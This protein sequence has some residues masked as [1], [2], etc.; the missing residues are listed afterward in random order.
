MTDTSIRPPTL[1]SLQGRLMWPGDPGY[2][3]ARRVFNAIFDRRPA[4]VV[5]C[6]DSEDVVQGLAYARATGAEV[7]VYGGGHAVTGAAVADGAVCLDL[8]GMKGIDIDPVAQVARVDAGC[9]WGEFDAAAQEHGLAVTGGRV[10][11]TGV[12]GL[13]LGSGSGWLER[14]LGYTC[15]SLLAAEVVTADG[16][17]VTASAEV[18][19]ELFWGIRGG[20]GNFGVVTQLTFRLH[21]VGPLLLGGMLLYPASRAFDVLRSWTTFMATAPDEVGG[22][23]AFITAPPADFV[24]PALRGQPVVAVIVVHHGDLEQGQE[25]LAPLLAFGP[26]AVSMVQP[27]PYLALQQLIEGGNPHGM[28]NYWSADFY[29]DLPDE[30]LRTLCSSATPPVSPLTQ[31]ICVRSGGAIARVPEDATAFGNRAVKY[32]VHYLSMWADPSEDD[33]NIDFTRAILAAMKPWST[34]GVYLNFIGDEGG[35]RVRSAFS[36]VKWD[37]LQALKRVWDPDNVFRHNQNIPPG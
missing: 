26:P 2:D 18:N 22:A 30:A 21:P 20:G 19:P 25:R 8:R 12:A 10:P 17:V 3:E 16:H 36:S 33:R 32:N 5:R 15:D 7:T 14:S 6:A 11:S 28:R 27:M 13:A 31:V 23:V 37:R 24:P 4:L 9:T 29:G 1:H 34:G 35:A